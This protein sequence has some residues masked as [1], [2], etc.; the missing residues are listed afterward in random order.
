[1]AENVFQKRV[2]EELICAI[3]LDFLREPKVLAC[4][5]SFCRECLVGVHAKR[6]KEPSPENAELSE[7][8]LECPSCRHFTKLQ[9]GNV[10]NL[11]THC[12]LANLVAI[13]SEEE[14]E[15]ARMIIRLR[16]KSPGRQSPTRNSIVDLPPCDEHRKP[17]EYYCEDCSQLLCMRCMLENHRKHNFE[18]ALRVVPEHLANMRNLIQPAF[19][20]VSRAEEAMKQLE[21]DKELI[22]A[23]RNTCAESIREVCNKMRDAIANREQ[24]LL[25]TVDKYIDTKLKLV[26]CQNKNL[27]EKRNLVLENVESIQKLLE[28]TTDVLVLREG[29]ALSDQLDL[30]EEAILEAES[31]VLKSK[32]SSSY[33]GFKDESVPHT[34]QQIAKLVTMLEFYPES[35]SGYYSSRE[36]IVEGEENPYV[37]VNYDK[38]QPSVRFGQTLVRKMEPI[39]DS[40]DS[41]VIEEDHTPAA[42]EAGSDEVPEEVEEEMNTPTAPI[43]FDSLLAPSPILEPV[44]VLDKLGRSKSD[45]VYPCGVCT[46]MNDC[47]VISDAKNH[48]L[49]MITANGK[50]I[51]TIGTEG[52]GNGD[53]EEPCGLAV[54]HYKNILVAQKVNSRIQKFTF[55]GKFVAKFGQRSLLGS[56]LGE[57][58]AIAV[59]PEGNIYVSDWDKGCI[60]I[61]GKKGRYLRSL[62]NEKDSTLAG[63]L[64]FPAGIAFNHE[65]NL[66]VADR[67][68]H[69]VWTLEPNSGSI[70]GKLGSTGHAPGELYYPYGVAVAKNGSIVIT[71]SGNYRI[72]VFSPSGQFQQCFGRRGAE[73]GMFDHPRHLCVTSKGEIVV[74][75]EMNQRLQVFQLSPTVHT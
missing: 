63:S 55:G 37:E 7:N 43:R 6:I 29:Q 10:D 21:E 74:A 28:R 45:S 36:I 57:S 62:G 19:E 61:F 39:N 58:W 71:E 40:P 34:V 42:S 8:E 30:Q 15:H 18:E 41:G 47:L 65:G 52:K 67:S 46:T 32:Y 35:D 22:E 54:D 72:S 16:Q 23:N 38:P 70:L 64:K 1:M 48:C 9:E 75:D 14:K 68:N 2:R 17:L 50:F 31:E 13:V 27:S 5:H 59:S 20:F 24:M 26:E 33:V 53:F 3:C 51:D 12:K 49:R 60:H 25:S 11:T 73:P 69:C 66:L 44:K 56:V 4:A